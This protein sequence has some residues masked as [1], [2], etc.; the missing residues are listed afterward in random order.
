MTGLCH[1]VGGDAAEVAKRVPGALSGFAGA[2]EAT[3]PVAQQSFQ[4]RAIIPCGTEVPI[5][6]PPPDRPLTENRS[7]LSLSQVKS[8]VPL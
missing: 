2:G 8:P 7:P 4:D 6:F 1:H 5:T 3:Q